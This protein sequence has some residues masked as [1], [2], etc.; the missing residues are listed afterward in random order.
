MADIVTPERRS[1]MMASIKGRN[2]RPELVVRRG[3]HGIGFR[4]RLDGAGLPGRPDLVL[5]KHRAAIFVHGCFWH[6]HEGC[7]LTSLPATRPDFW[8]LKF[9]GNV[10]RDIRAQEAL[11]ASGWRVAIVWECSTRGDSN[12]GLARLAEWLASDVPLI[13]IP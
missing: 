9:R 10:E 13:V 1:R 6:R 4:Y 3:L 2:T 8:Q 12:Q 11:Q 5:P 7:R